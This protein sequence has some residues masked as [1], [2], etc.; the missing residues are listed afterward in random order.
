V[1]FVDGDRGVGRV[2]DWVLPLCVLV[3]LLFLWEVEATDARPEE[4]RS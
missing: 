3:P 2:F 4:Q 1:E